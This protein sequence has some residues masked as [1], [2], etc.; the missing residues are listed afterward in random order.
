MLAFVREMD[1]LVDIEFSRADPRTVI[2]QDAA[3]AAVG[4][5]SMACCAH[6]GYF[7]ISPAL[8]PRIDRRRVGFIVSPALFAE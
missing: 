7:A 1:R 5:V 8:I 4:R 6:T 3:V 2:V